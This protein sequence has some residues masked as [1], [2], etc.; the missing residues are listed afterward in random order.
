MSEEHR[1]RGFEVNNVM[2]LDQ[3]I[4]SVKKAG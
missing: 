1:V 4:P 2:N 3:E